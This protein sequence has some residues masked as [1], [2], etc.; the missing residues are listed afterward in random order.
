M[1]HE[2]ALERLRSA[3]LTGDKLVEAMRGLS[4]Q[5]VDLGGDGS[6]VFPCDYQHAGD[7]VEADTLVPQLIL[8]MRRVEVPE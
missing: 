4:K 8:V 1:I 6:F 3:A 7:V 2:A 5:S